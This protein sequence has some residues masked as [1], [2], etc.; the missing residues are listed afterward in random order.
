MG[1]A[2]HYED[3]V[4]RYYM[5]IEKLKKEIEAKVPKNEFDGHSFVI[6]S[7][8]ILELCKGLLSCF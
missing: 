8:H 5:E 7:N 3:I 1:C 4:N 2:S 6:K